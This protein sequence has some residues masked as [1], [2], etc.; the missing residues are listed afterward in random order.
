MKLDLIPHMPYMVRGMLMYF[1]RTRDD[2]GALEFYHIQPYG[3]KKH[4]I[5]FWDCDLKWKEIEKYYGPMIK[6]SDIL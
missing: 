1:F 6:M 4:T 5:H 3:P 2:N